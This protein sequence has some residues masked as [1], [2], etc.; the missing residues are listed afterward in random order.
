MIIR[1]GGAGEVVVE[2]GYNV[3]GYGRNK[4]G[5]VVAHCYSDFP[6]NPNQR[7][8]VHLPENSPIL[9]ALQAL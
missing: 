4:K 5:Q 3:V 7:N 1:K 9:R 6:H 2:D 8:I